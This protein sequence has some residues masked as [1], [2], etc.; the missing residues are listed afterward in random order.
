MNTLPK[1]LNRNPETVMQEKKI[2]SGQNIIIRAF[3]PVDLDSLVSV[4]DALEGI[5]KIKPAL[6]EMGFVD[7]VVVT[8]RRHRKPQPAAAE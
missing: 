2:E 7:V 5:E 1:F 4:R 8:K 3:K 6:Q